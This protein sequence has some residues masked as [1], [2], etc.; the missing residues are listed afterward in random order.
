MSSL[1]VVRFDHEPCFFPG[2]EL[3]GILGKGEMDCSEMGVG[4]SA[5]C[6]WRELTDSVPGAK[7]GGR[8]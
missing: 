8:V 2:F 3:R 7:R 1:A 4:L 6:G 5:E